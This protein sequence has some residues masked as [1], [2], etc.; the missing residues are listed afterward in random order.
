M[1][2]KILSGQKMSLS[3]L[4]KVSAEVKQMA[5]A[6][7]LAV[8]LV[9]NN[10]ASQVYV[11]NKKMPVKKPELILLAMNYQKPLPKHNY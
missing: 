2:D 9:G 10:P 7:S 11:N 1:Q 8:I 3:L 4:D 5:K 6:P